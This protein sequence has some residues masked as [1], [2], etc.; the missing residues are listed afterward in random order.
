M[1]TDGLPPSLHTSVVRAAEQILCVLA[2]QGLDSAAPP[3]AY[4]R[5]M[6]AAFSMKRAD[7]VA[8]DDMQVPKKMTALVDA[9]AKLAA[10]HVPAIR[11]LWSEVALQWSTNAPNRRMACRSLQ[12]M[13]ALRPTYP[14]LTV[15]NLVARLAD[16]LAL[17]DAI[18]YTLE[19]LNTLEALLATATADVLPPIYL[20]LIHI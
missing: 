18:P 4:L 3:P 1:Y 8:L 11:D 15:P 2:T 13:R 6:H 7:H 5:A 20:S 9:L 14:A 17:S 12:I 16:T 19:A 10:P